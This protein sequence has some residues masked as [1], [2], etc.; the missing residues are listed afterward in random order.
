MKTK[1]IDLGMH[2]YAD[3]FIAKNQL[4]LAEPIYPLE[5][6]LDQ[7][8]GLVQ[9]MY[10][11]DSHE[12]YNLYDY[13]YTGSNSKFARD[14]WDSYAAHTVNKIGLPPSSTIIEIGSNDGYLSKQYLKKGYKVEGIDSSKYMSEWAIKEGVFTHNFIFT[15]K[16]AKNM[17]F[18]GLSSDLIVANNVFNHANDPNDFAL[19]VEELLNPEGVFIFEVPYWYNTVVDRRFDQIYH[20]HVSYFTVKSACNLLA[21]AGLTVY[22]VEWVNYHGGSIRVYASKTEL[23]SSVTPKVQEFIQQEENAGLFDSRVYSEFMTAIER[24]RAKFLTTLYGL[25]SS[26]PIVGVGA[27]AKGNTFLNFYNLDSTI[28]NYV[29]DSSQHKIGK[30]TP[31]SRIP[32]ESDEEVFKKYDKVFAVMLSWNISDIIKK[33]LLEINSNIT[34][35]KI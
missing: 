34:F 24:D 17:R 18:A 27:A 14:H 30:Y 5:C 22:D 29:T 35:L 15:Q 12:R 4:S 3:T 21:K 33:K 8:T 26:F 31:L 23:N 20:E 2:P 10:K 32:I 19:G 25:D 1:I 9:T 7:E 6:T 13:S 16:V 11:T 28:I